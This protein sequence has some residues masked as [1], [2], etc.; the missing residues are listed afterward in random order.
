[1]SGR[2]GNERVGHAQHLARWR[3]G[4]IAHVEQ[5]RAAGVWQVDVERRVAEQF[6]DELGVEGAGHGLD[7]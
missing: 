2:M 3:S 4:G 6:V 7:I 5:E 1:M